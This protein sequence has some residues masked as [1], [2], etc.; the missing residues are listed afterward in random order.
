MMD[1]PSRDGVAAGTVADR[2]AQP[3]TV[4]TD[5]S[6]GPGHTHGSASAGRACRIALGK[7]GRKILIQ[8]HIEPAICREVP[9]CDAPGLP[10]P[11][12]RAQAYTREGQDSP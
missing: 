7:G 2:Q 8:R 9:P 6:S 1:R 12:P 5:T 4:V 11:A 3:Q 10:S